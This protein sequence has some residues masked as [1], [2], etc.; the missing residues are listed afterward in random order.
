MGSDGLVGGETH[1]TMDGPIEEIAK[2]EAEGAENLLR[3]LG[4]PVCLFTLLLLLLLFIFVNCKFR[5]SHFCKD[6]RASLMI[7]HYNF[8][9]H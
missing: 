2:L 5:L 1:V 9:L 6:L 8:W 3:H 7:C 4:I